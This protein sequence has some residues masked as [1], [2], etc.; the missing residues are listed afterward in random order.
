VVLAFI[1]IILVVGEEVVLH[2]SLRKRKGERVAVSYL[3]D[4]DGKEERE[5]PLREA[6]RQIPHQ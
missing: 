6:R 5:S 2:L 4:T 1:T 3:E